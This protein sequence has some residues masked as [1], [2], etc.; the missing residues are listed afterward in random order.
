MFSYMEASN[1]GAQW[2]VPGDSGGV[3]SAW[4]AG[5]ET[6]GTWEIHD[7][8]AQPRNCGAGRESQLHGGRATGSWKSDH[9][10]VLR[11]GRADHMGRG[12]A[13]MRSP[14]R[15]HDTDRNDW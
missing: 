14:Q 15:K 2:R 11:D 7:P 8:P 5:R 9:F 1:K 12:V 3:S 6:P 10:I 13:G 4:H